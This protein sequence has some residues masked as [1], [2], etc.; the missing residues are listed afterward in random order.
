MAPKG[1]CSC[2]PS[3]EAS[4]GS[5]DTGKIRQTFKTEAAAKSWRAEA[6]VAL[7]KGALRVTA[8][9]TIR[10]A[11][12]RLVAGMRDGSIRTRSGRIYKPSVI[13]GYEQGLRI[14]IYPDLG[15]AKLSAVR[16]QDVQRLADRLHAK[17][18]N[19]S[20]I[21]NSLMPL[22]VVYR[23]AVEDGDVLVNPVVALRLPAVEGTRD[24]IAEP[25]EGAALIAALRTSDRALWGCALYAGLRAGELRALDWMDV[26]LAAGVIRVER[27][28]DHKGA[29]VSPKSDAGRRSVPIAAVLRDLLLE[30][31]LV[32]WASGYVFGSSSSTP[33]THSAVMRRARLRWT[34]AV[35]AELGLHEARHTFASMMIAAGVNAKALSTYMGHSSIGVTLDIYGHLMPG[36]EDEA[37][38]LLDAYLVRADTAARVRQ[39][40][41]RDAV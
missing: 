5:G 8:P 40:E 41:A 26:D 21:R 12:D 20:T 38:A 3:W 35:L 30:H 10:E 39:M 13:R 6:V 23:R 24:R 16:R 28:M 29:T 15:G 27:S 33:F 34:K 22:R 17:A 25:A 4:V 18:A 9:T 36:N 2:R 14:Y 31:K 11:G 32:T 19:P 7:N 1:R 37:A